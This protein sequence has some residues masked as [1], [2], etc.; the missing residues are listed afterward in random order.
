MCD[1]NARCGHCIHQRC[2][3]NCLYDEVKPKTMFQETAN[4]VGYWTS[5]APVADTRPM[6]VKKTNYPTT[7]S[8]TNAQYRMAMHAGYR[9]V[10]IMHAKLAIVLFEENE[11]GLRDACKYAVPKE[12]KF[13]GD[14]YWVV[15]F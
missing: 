2:N 4:A 13:T 10:K 14:V 8:L 7:F 11:F 12:D 15:R 1:K 3:K 6:L 5:T 9:G